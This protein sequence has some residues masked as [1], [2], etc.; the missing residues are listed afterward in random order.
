[1]RNFLRINSADTASDFF[2]KKNARRLAGRVITI[3]K[4]R[5]SG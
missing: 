1:M 4:C 2:D 5:G 3:E